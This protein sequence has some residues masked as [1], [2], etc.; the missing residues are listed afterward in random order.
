[1][2]ALNEYIR[3]PLKSKVWLKNVEILNS[4]RSAINLKLTLHSTFQT[5]N[6]T[7]SF[8]FNRWA[9]S[10]MESM[11]LPRVPFY[12]Y[13]SFPK[14]YDPRGLPQS[15]KALALQQLFQYE[16]FLKGK[17]LTALEESW[18]GVMKSHFKTMQEEPTSKESMWKNFTETTAKVDQYRQQRITDYL[19]EFNGY[20]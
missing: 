19:P 20:L 3:F 2:P 16:E 9:W 12:I 13:V 4:W 1:A 15:L 7:R 14:H 8:E 5:L 18:L 17:P 11:E 6:A 10:F